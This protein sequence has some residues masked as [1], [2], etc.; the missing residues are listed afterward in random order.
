MKERKKNLNSFFA[1]LKQMKERRILGIDPGYDRC[2]VAIISGTMHKPHVVFSCCIETSKTQKFHE[3]ILFIFKCLSDIIEEHKPIECSIEDIFI[4]NNQK[5]AV[6]VSEA[7]GVCLLAAAY[8]KLKIAEYTPLQIK[9]YLT[10]YG[11]ADKKQIHFIV[12]KILERAQ[13][14]YL[15]EQKRLDDEID[16]VAIALTHLFVS[17]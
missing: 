4:T 17:R 6:K 2:G 3:R 1:I 5:T 16:A 7:R 12:K 9:T 8:F 15:T 14:E 11:K 13:P 10:S